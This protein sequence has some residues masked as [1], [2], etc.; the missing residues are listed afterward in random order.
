MSSKDARRYCGRDFT[1]EEL[2]WIRRW[3]QDNPGRGRTELSMRFC[4]HAGWQKPDGQPKAMSCRVALLRME[5]DGLIKLP[6]RLTRND[7]PKGKKRQWTLL[8]N[9]QPPVQL[10]AGKLDLH[11]EPVTRGTSMLWNEFIDRYHYLGYTPLPGAQL[12]YFVKA[13]GQTLALLGF[14][15]AAWKTAPRD[16]WIGW[17][18]AQR[19]KNLHRVVQNC[20]YLILP[21]IR[22]RYLASRILS[23]V[24]KRLADD[25]QARYNYRPVLLETFVEKQRFKGTCYKAAGWTCVGDTKGRGKL[26]VHKEY[27]L[28]VKSV[29]LKPLDKHCR[30]MLLE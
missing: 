2:D 7:K 20:R 23:T 21:W 29:W 16:T 28:P 19:K 1:D 8:C 11:F 9:P 27:K 12:R 4:E 17:S 10:E 18:H 5:K 24:S 26:D 30:Q 25:W 15:A 3:I 6:P 14:G 22:C 13:D